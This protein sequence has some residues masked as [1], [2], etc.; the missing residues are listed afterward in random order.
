MLRS[1]C[2][3]LEVDNIELA[4]GA[5]KLGPLSLNAAN[6]EYLVILGPTG[7]GKTL[8]LEAIAGLRPLTAG[9]IAIDGRDLSGAAPED[10]HVGFL[11]QDSLLFPHLSVRR[12][13]AY[14][15]RRTPRN[16]RG[17]T[18]ERLAASLGIAPILDR[19][20]G[21]LSGGERQRVALA[22]ALAANPSLMLLDE[23]MAA[24]DPNSRY[25]LRQTLLELH[26]EL[27]TTTI[28]VT[29]SFSEARE[30]ADRIAILID[31]HVIQSGTPQEVFSKPDSIEIARFLRSATPAAEPAN[32]NSGS[33]VIIVRRLSIQAAN[34]NPGAEEPKIIAANAMIA[35]G[36]RDSIDLVP[37]RV[38]SARSEDGRIQLRLAA[39]LDLETAIDSATGSADALSPGTCVWLKI[40]GD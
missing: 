5:F 39:G 12:N 27:G 33:A 13:V 1:G 21:G 17:A 38:L 36:A 14:G 26:R 3:R 20:P 8:T 4:A 18:V 9:K 10:R 31:G 23:P 2:M 25:A 11:Y 6:G 32:L 29:H 15:A 34:G 40:A 7:A 35:K 19:M 16:Q 28:H 30:L 24:L 22:R 37:A